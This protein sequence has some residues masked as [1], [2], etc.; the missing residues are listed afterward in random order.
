MNI[1]QRT[2][3]FDQRIQLPNLTRRVS[4][5]IATGKYYSGINDDQQMH[6]ERPGMAL[7]VSTIGA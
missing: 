1:A 3:Q 5:T 6:L 2:R 4:I 7:G